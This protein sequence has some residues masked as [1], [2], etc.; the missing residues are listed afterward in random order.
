MFDFILALIGLVLLCPIL[1]FVAC[2]IKLDSPGPV[3]FLQTRTGEKGHVFRIIKFR[4]MKVA[5]ESLGK[6]TVGEGDARITKSGRLIR[7]YKIDE[8]P[9]LLNVLLGEMSFVGPRPEV[10]EFIATYP[11]DVK[12]KVLS[13]K[14]GITD[15]A[16]I[17][18]IDENQMLAEYEDPHEAYVSMVLPLKQKMYV[19]YV[20]NQSFFGDVKIILKTI[21]KVFS[22]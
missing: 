16:S 18:M 17:F 1:L 4:T 7:K 12:T 21:L 19:D 11:I 20:D 9:Q 15:N 13:V 6:L 10:P 22:R 8:L 5:S 2:W 14:P 3:L